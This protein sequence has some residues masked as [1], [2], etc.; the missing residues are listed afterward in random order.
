MKKLALFAVLLTLTAASFAIAQE[1]HHWGGAGTP[2]ALAPLAKLEGTWIGKAGDGTHE[3]D[4]TV[5]Y[6]V[7]ANG[8]AVIET[9][10][11]GTDHEMVTMYTVD[12]G[13]L[14][15][16]HYCS[17]GNQPHMKARAGGDGK[18]ITFDFAGGANINP[19]K[20]QFMHDARMVFVD[21]DHLRT[22][23]GD[24]NGGKASVRRTF[25]LTRQK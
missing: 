3:M 2:A 1:T 13:T 8:S 19:S 12:K 9:L 18:E 24:W 14:V 16:T 20:D 25:E 10:F 5:T 21:D 6:K 4:A 23:W 22:E 7:T 15:L 17:A 11:P